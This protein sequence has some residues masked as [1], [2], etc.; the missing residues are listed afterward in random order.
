[1]SGVYYLDC[2]FNGFKGELISVALVPADLCWPKFYKVLPLPSRID[3]WVEKHVIPFLNKEPEP[4]D[5][6]QRELGE[7]LKDAKEVIADWPE[8][9]AHLCKLLITGPGMRL[10]CYDRLSFIIDASLD[11]SLSRI[12]HNALE[13]AI[14]IREADS[15]R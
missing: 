5:V 15:T 11:S 6:V 3:P 4:M 14:A 8:D 13:D 12:P 9:I 7:Y 10:R 1:M 2:E